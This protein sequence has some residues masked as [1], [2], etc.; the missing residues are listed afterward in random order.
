MYKVLLLLLWWAV[1]TTFDNQK[2]IIGAFPGMQEC[3]VALHKEVA[4]GRAKFGQCVDHNPYSGYS[5][6]SDRRDK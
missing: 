5:T 2:Y 6:P 1:L 4:S 3:Y